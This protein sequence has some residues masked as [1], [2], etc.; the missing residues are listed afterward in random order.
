MNEFDPF[1]KFTSEKMKENTIKFLDTTVFINNTSSN[2]L[3]MKM[4]L[5]IIKRQFHLSKI[6]IHV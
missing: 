6:K 2:F 1:L 3:N 5:L 4:L